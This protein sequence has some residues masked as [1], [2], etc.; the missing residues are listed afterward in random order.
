MNCNNTSRC[1]TSLSTLRPT[2]QLL[3]MRLQSVTDS[4]PS[5]KNYSICSE[6]DSFHLARGRFVT[7][8]WILFSITFHCFCHKNDQVR[9]MRPYIATESPFLH[10]ETLTQ[11]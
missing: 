7:D 3:V 6:G 9:S 2:D 4:V 5:L 8:A 1:S 11:Q 10:Q